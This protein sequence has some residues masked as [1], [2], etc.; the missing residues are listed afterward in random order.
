MLWS[1]Y[2]IVWL[3]GSEGFG[4]ASPTLEV[5]LFLILDLFAKVGFGFLLLTNR[6]TLSD[7]G[8]GGQVGASRVR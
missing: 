6:R 7:A 5:F 4:A 1:C 8:G 2:P 3:L